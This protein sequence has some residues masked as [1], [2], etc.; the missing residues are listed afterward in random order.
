MSSSA[1]PPAGRITVVEQGDQRRKYEACKQLVEEIAGGRVDTVAP[2]LR[3][4]I[5][6]RFP[7]GQQWCDS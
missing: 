7:V 5:E 3:S 2:I 4:T 1:V 6:V